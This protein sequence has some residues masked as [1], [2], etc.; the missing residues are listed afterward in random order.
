RSRSRGGNAL[1]MQVHELAEDLRVDAEAL[2]A[3]LRQMGIPVADED[4]TITDGQMA[5]V[6]ARVER[7]RRAGR[8]D[9]AAAIMAA[10]EDATPTAGRRRRRRRREDVPEPE[11]EAPAEAEAPAAEAEPEPAAV[12]T[13]PEP[14]EAPA[15]EEPEP[16]PERAPEPARPEPVEAVQA[17][18]E[19]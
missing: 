1:S 5:K 15:A 13:E 16:E 7:E 4:A 19:V 10:L 3:L 14:V 17:E 9:P 2:I 8:K 6:L 11:P 18:P 12:A